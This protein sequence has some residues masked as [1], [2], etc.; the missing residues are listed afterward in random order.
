MSS[1]RTHTAQHWRVYTAIAWSGVL[2]CLVGFWPHTWDYDYLVITLLLS[3]TTATTIVAL[4][5]ESRHHIWEWYSEL[6]DELEE[7]QDSSAEGRHKAPTVIHLSDATL[8]NLGR[9][10]D[11]HAR[12]SSGMTPGK[13]TRLGRRLGDTPA[14][15]PAHQSD[16]EVCPGDPEHYRRAHDPGGA[17]YGQPLDHSP[18]ATGTDDFE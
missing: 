6:Y 12:T 13:G 11:E 2:V 18:A 1:F 7:I 16:D 9:M 5:E 10:L 4:S 8:D 14:H 3:A 15:S 17:W